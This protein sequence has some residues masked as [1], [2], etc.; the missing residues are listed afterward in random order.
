MPTAIGAIR[1]RLLTPDLSEV[2]FQKRG[3]HEKDPEVRVKL[4]HVGRQ[5]LTGFGHAMVSRDMDETERLL[6]PVERAYRGFA[7]EG[8]AMAYAI[9]DAMSPGKRR[10]IREFAEGPAL[11]HVYMVHVGIGWAMARLPRML[12]GRKLLPDPLLRWLAFDG[13]GF[14]QAYFATRTYVEERRVSTVRA[15]WPDPSGYTTRAVDQ[16]IGRAMWFVCG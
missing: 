2:T 13:Y 3:F 14:H 7:Y 4:E 16:G 1:K 15:P 8:A 11:T 12:W 10:R 5:F 6:A 9:T